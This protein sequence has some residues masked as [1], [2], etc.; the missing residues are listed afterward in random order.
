MAHVLVTTIVIRLVGVD[1]TQ[2]EI[3]KNLIFLLYR[4]SGEGVNKYI[5][6]DSYEVDVWLV[7]LLQVK[8]ILGEERECTGQ[9]LS[10]DEGEGV[11]K[12]DRGNINMI[13]LN[14]LCKMPNDTD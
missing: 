1:L 5:C 9:L 6:C 14:H 11:V 13:Q 10:I 2:K 8:V 3:L 4:K 12:L 7:C